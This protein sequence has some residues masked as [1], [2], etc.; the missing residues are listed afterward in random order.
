MLMSMLAATF[1]WPF[2]LSHIDKTPLDGP[3]RSNFPMRPRVNCNDEM[4]LIMLCV[5]HSYVMSLWQCADW[6]RISGVGPAC[7]RSPGIRCRCHH[8]LA[9]HK[10]LS[11]S[12]AANQLGI[13][14]SS[15]LLSSTCQQPKEKSLAN[16]QNAR[17]H[18]YIFQ[19]A[20]QWPL[21]SPEWRPSVLGQCYLIL[22]LQG[23]QHLAEP[24]VDG[25]VVVWD[26]PQAPGCQMVGIV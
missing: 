18:I 20:T 25:P 13:S 3:W 10:T 8:S 19:L 17:Y 15:P 14:H 1:N 5:T 21:G 9:S 23:L 26:V 6:V 7:C 12:R 4:A 22:W 24:F 16:L 2:C 11:V